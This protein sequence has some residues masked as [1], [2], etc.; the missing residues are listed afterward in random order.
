MRHTLEKTAEQLRDAGKKARLIY[1][2]N[3][4]GK[5]P[6]D[7]DDKRI[8]GFLFRHVTETC[9]YSPLEEQQND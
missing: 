4:V 3:G 2:F 6:P 8:L 7:E 5:T 1:A 9:G